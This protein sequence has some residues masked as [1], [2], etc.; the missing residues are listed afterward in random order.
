MEATVRNRLRRLTR[1]QRA[2]GLVLASVL[3]VLAGTAGRYAARDGGLLV[4]AEL[5]HHPL[6]F[7]L[8]TGA[9]LTTAAFL[10]FRG[11]IVRVLVGALSALLALAGL[12]FA[13]FALFGAAEETMD[14]PAPGR[15]DR[16]LVIE[17]GAA[18]IDPLWWVYVDEG[19]GLTKRRWRVG[20]F[21][22]DDPANALA[23]ASWAGPDRIR[24]V[25]GDPESGAED[26][27]DAPRTHF[28]DL[29]PETGR[30]L[31]TIESG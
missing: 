22:G 13:L 30:P 31:R 17:E 6:L 29:V 27:V 8:L 11:L 3:L 10:A 23:E 12:P 5:F 7:A 15:T 4:V 19:S 2:L 26:G 25:T 1:R 28:I 24:L 14:T 21:N 9:A 20:H 18:L 16:H